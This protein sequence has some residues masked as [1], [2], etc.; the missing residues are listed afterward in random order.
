MSIPHLLNTSQLTTTVINTI[1]DSAEAIANTPACATGLLKGSILATCFLQPST[2]TRLS[3]ESAMLRLGGTL[4][5][6]PEQSQLRSESLSDFLLCIDGY[7]DIITIRHPDHEEVVH[8]STQLHNPVINCGTGMTDHPTQAL[9]DIFMIKRTFGEIK[10]RRVLLLGDYNLRASK[11]LL[12]IKD[13]VGL[14]VDIC[15]PFRD[16]DL[17]LQKHIESQYG[18]A[19]FGIAN[20]ESLLPEYDVIYVKPLSSVDYQSHT[21]ER[22]MLDI[23]SVNLLAYKIAKH[24]IPN[25]T[26]ILHAF[27]RFTELD[28]LIDAMP[29]A[30]Y[31]SLA[32]LAVYV[33]MA[34]LLYVK[35]KHIS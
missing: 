1:L 4:L 8:A 15:A 28:T 17:A 31:F 3:M 9:A 2:R 27:P 30:K 25:S 22:G 5:S 10:A 34:L 12:T 13:K 32:H 7:A 11:A 24:C 6:V 33:R 35:G 19:T 20:L 29:Q 26:I 16:E 14:V 21:L 23:N 18:C